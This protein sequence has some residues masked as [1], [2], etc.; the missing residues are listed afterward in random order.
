[1]KNYDT[2]IEALQDLKKRGYEI[3][4][5]L[6]SDGSRCHSGD[7]HLHPEDF[8]I[9]EMYRFEGMSSPDDNSVVY[10][11]ESKTGLKGVLVDAY[12]VYAEAMT[13]E[14]ARKLGEKL[15]L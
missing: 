10:A 13:P 11:I 3:D 12:G 8:E 2:L 7:L 5:N 4:F 9:R 6:H 1:M 15:E 14:M